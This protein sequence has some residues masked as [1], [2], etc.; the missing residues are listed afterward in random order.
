MT[1]PEQRAI[2]EAPSRPEEIEWLRAP[3]K[4]HGGPPQPYLSQSACIRRL[5]AAFEG[6]WSLDLVAPPLWEGDAREGYVTVVCRISADG[7]IREHGGGCWYGKGMPKGD[8]LK[9]AITL[10]FRKACTTF[11]MGLDLFE[12]PPHVVG[13]LTQCS[14][15]LGLSQDEVS[16]R[17]C[18]KANK[19]LK[20]FAREDCDR[21][22]AYLLKQEEKKKPPPASTSGTPPAPQASGE[23]ASAG[24]DS[25]ASPPSSEKASAGSTPPASQAE[26][27]RD[28][29]RKIG[30]KGLAR[31]V[32]AGKEKGF[33]HAAIQEFAKSKGKTPSELT[34]DEARE[35]IDRSKGGTGA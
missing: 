26:P 11:G 12:L 19:L 10:S 24:S 14:L 21:A 4:L 31:L 5:N 20:E 30:T 8:S 22:W 23:Q 9:G 33:D 13:F 35:L 34:G 18:R 15:Q 27:S 28:G 7:Q 17:I 1:T 3:E 16:A 6:Q 2:L 29:G 32:A 25:P